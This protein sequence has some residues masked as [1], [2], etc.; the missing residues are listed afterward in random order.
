MLTTAKPERRRNFCYDISNDGYYP[1]DKGKATLIHNIIFLQFVIIRLKLRHIP[2]RFVLNLWMD[3]CSPTLVDIVEQ[4]NDLSGF[5]FPSADCSSCDF[6]SIAT[7]SNIP[8]AYDRLT[9][10]LDIFQK[11]YINLNSGSDR[12]CRGLYRGKFVEHSPGNE[13]CGALNK[14]KFLRVWRK[15]IETNKWR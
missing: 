14:V 8:M 4:C 1:V 10:R 6:F 2:G 7:W 12:N 13:D 11:L 3:F 5:Q 15:E 9:S